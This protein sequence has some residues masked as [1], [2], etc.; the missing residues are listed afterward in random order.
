MPKRDR[1]N[2]QPRVGFNWNPKTD[3]DGILGFLTGGDKL[4]VRGGYAVTHDYAFTNIAS[5]IA[6]A[7]P[8]LAAVDLPPTLP[9]ADGV[10]GVNNAF[11]RLPLIQGATGL[12]PNNLTRTIVSEDFR[13]PYYQQF[14][15]EL[16]R[17][18]TRDIV[19]LPDM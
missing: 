10:P 5:N 9:Q 3:T 12:N 19:M 11:A 4:V 14:S 13:S 6:S 7:F 16:Q 18:L 15:F 2:F 8:F 17:E 1:N